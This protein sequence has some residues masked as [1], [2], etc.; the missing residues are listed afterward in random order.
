[1]DMLWAVTGVDGAGR[2]KATAHPRREP[3]GS[4]RSWS[5]QNRGAG[6][7]GLRVLLSFEGFAEL[8]AL[9]DRVPRRVTAT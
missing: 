5:Q 1:M 2:G 9:G 8:S 6:G 4:H 3:P 7:A